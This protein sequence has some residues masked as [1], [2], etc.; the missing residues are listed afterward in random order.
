M[1]WTEEEWQK[2]MEG[3]AIRRIGYTRWRRNLAVAMGNALRSSKLP[4]DVR[5]AM[6][7]VL[8]EAIAD[9]RT[10]E[11]VREHVA[12]ALENFDASRNRMGDGQC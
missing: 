9:V 7:R 4:A 1:A 8:G 6:T 12:W 11:L 3:S 5:E 10:T 2:R